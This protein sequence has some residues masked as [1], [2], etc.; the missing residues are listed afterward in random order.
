[1][2]NTKGMEWQAR[3]VSY[4]WHQRRLLEIPL[5]DS[6]VRCCLCPSASR[7]TGVWATSIFLP[8]TPDASLSAGSCPDCSFVCGMNHLRDAMAGT[9][10]VTCSVVRMGVPSVGFV[11]T[12]LSVIDPTNARLALGGSS[13]GA[14]WGSSWDGP[15]ATLWSIPSH[16]R[17]TGHI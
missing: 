14:M 13:V 6:H 3:V 16:N 11:A 2:I 15:L 10:P 5:L 12:T 9:L 1:M 8:T 4:N 7:S 17:S